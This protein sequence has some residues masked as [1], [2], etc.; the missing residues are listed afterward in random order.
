MFLFS[1]FLG[2][3]GGV[4]SLILSFLFCLD[5]PL[6]FFV[7]ACF[8]LCRWVFPFFFFLT[9]VSVC[10]ILSFVFRRYCFV[11]W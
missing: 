2:G 6:S 8:V 9:S 4:F 3:G 7:F 1:F 10:R 5:F 11:L